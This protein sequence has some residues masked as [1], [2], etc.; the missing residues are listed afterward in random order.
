V[1]C[2]ADSVRTKETPENDTMIAIRMK[3]VLTI[4]NT[5]PTC[6]EIVTFIRDGRLANSGQEDI[7]DSLLTEKER[8]KYHRF[9]SGDMLSRFVPPKATLSYPVVVNARYNVLEPTR[10]LYEHVL[11]IYRD[12]FGNYHDIYSVWKIRF[13]T[14]GKAVRDK[15]IKYDYH[16]YTPNEIKRILGKENMHRMDDEE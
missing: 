9:A 4:E 15:G 12:T 2:R 3:Y 1:L 13:D 6:A 14:K 11:I 8:D 16:E 5:G 10:D 7:R